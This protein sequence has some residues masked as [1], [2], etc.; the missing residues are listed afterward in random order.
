MRSQ[1]GVVKRHSEWL[2]TFIRTLP[3]GQINKPALNSLSCLSFTDNIL[4][5][6]VST[7]V[8]VIRLMTEFYLILFYVFKIAS[9]KHDPDIRSGLSV[10][11]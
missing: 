2:L 5:F 10:Q 4:G 7:L 3:M 11:I 9:L 6:V 8:S 1:Q